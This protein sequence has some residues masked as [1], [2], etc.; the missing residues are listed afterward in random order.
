MFLKL[1]H[2]SLEVFK[3]SKLFALQCYRVAKL[4]P[5]EER[6]AMCLQIRRAGLS[7]YLNLAEGCS[8]R[9]GGE[10]KRYFEISRGSIIEVDAAM[11]M[12]F[13]LKYVTKA[14]LAELCM[15]GLECFKM[16]SAMIGTK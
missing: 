6:F 14:D 7:V 10:R 16:L 13:D 12:A 15:Y 4:L 3:L 2:Q 11:D 9:S 1:N 5:T 8:R